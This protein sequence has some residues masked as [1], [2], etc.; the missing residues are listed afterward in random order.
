MN[1]DFKELARNAALRKAPQN[2]TIEDV[3]EAFRGELSKYCTSVAAFLKNRYDLYEIVVENVDSV[4]PQRI[5]KDLELVAEVKHVKQ[6]QKAVFKLGNRLSKMR[7]KKFLTQVG[8]S[9]VYETF[10]LDGSAF[11]LPMTAIGMGAT[12]DFERLLDGNETLADVIDVFTESYE[13]A[14]LLEVQKAL[15]AAINNPQMPT[16]NKVSINKFDSEK[17]AKLCGVVKKYSD[18]AVIFA[19]T[20]FI[21]AMGADAIVPATANVRGIYSP[22]DIEAIHNT[23]IINLFRGVPVVELKN[24]FV[25]TTNTTTY[26]DP[27]M[28]YVLPAGKEKVVVVGFEGDTQMYDAVNR[29]NSMEIMTYKKLGV[30]IKTFVNFGVYQNTGIAQTYFQA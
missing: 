25:D 30:G 8:L 19:P 20:E 1:K 6:G 11:E 18:G 16:P 7:A 28:A 23:G 22:D 10:R 5:S 27:Q 9:G 15:R 2:F 4:V 26:L 21:M 14:V 13:D 29:D 17:M 3:N 24:A 12:I